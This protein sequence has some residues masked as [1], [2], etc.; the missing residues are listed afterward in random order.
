MTHKDTKVILE[1]VSDVVIHV[2]PSANCLNTDKGAIT[3]TQ[4]RKASVCG[5]FQREDKGQEGR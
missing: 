3:E 1:M 5:L 2:L 4:V